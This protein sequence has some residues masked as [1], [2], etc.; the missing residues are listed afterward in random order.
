MVVKNALPNAAP[1]SSDD[2]VSDEL[3]IELLNELHI[4]QIRRQAEEDIA[5]FWEAARARFAQPAASE[6]AT[7][8]GIAVYARARG[9]LHSVLERRRTK[10]L[11]GLPP[12]TK[13]SRERWLAAFG[14]RV[15]APPVVATP[16]PSA[17]NATLSLIGP[18]E[19]L[20]LPAAPPWL[21]EDLWVGEGVGIIGAAPKSYKT[22]IALEM[23][24]AVASGTPCFGRFAV[25]N[26]GPVIAFFA[27]DSLQAIRERLLAVCAARGLEL[28]RLP[29]Q[30]VAASVLRLD[31]P[32]DQD[33]LREAVEQQQPR[34]MVL[35]PLVRLHGGDENDSGHI[36][37]LLG[38][39]RT[40]QRDYG[41]SIVLT[42]HNR[43]THSRHAP[44]GQGLRGSGD[45][46]AWTDTGLFLRRRSGVVTMRVEHRSAASPEPMRVALSRDPAPHLQVSDLVEEDEEAGL[47]L[48]GAESLETRTHRAIAASEAPLSRAALRALLRCRNESLTMVLRALVEQGKVRHV[49]GRWVAGET[50]SAPSRP[51]DP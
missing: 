46:H 43:K 14:A 3:V 6:G 10:E 23:A 41:S 31:A 12:K 28:E 22:W 40:L 48:H 13:L 8:V 21:I 19:L 47:P 36:G 49:D 27:E 29:L 9:A 1:D 25:P 17:S 45:L 4:H 35:D 50:S 34:L 51:C 26:P 42:H 7:E 32:E 16:A 38:F 33:R 37:R 18:R 5:P 30:L 11:P 44:E 15:E 2:S 24:V 39:L 20:D